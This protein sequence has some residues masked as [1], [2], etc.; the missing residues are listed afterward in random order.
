M[1]NKQSIE[2]IANWNGNIVDLCLDLS[3][4]MVKEVSDE[5]SSDLTDIIAETLF[6][7]IK[8]TI[9]GW[10]SLGMDVDDQQQNNILRLSKELETYNDFH[11]FEGYLY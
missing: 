5:I 11:P 1:L 8:E 4:K 3:S 7:P 2:N 6:Y 10:N 9:E